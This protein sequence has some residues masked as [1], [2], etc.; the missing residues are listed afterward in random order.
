MRS[1]GTPVNVA[2][3]PSRS[4]ATHNNASESLRCGA[5]QYARQHRYVQPV[6][7]VNTAASLACLI[8]L[9]GEAG[10]KPCSL[11]NVVNVLDQGLVT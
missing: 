1:S 2:S 3:V 7:I 10:Y 4:R 11:L 5:D 9:G 6:L 8:A